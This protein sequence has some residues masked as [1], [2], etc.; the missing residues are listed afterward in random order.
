MKIIKRGERRRPIWWHNLRA[1]CKECG[2]VIETEVDDYFRESAFNGSN[3][4]V[5]VT[6]V[7]PVCRELIVIRRDSLPNE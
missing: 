5:E 4:N 3:S 1:E 6:Y 2:S 7:C